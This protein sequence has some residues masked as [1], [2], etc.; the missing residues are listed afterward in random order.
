[1]SQSESTTN[2]LENVVNSVMGVKDP[3]PSNDSN[4]N[5]QEF[6]GKALLIY[7]GGT[8]V[9]IA[10]MVLALW[11]IGQAYTQL[12]R[13]NDNSW[14]PTAIASVFFTVVTLRSRLF[15]PLDNTR[16]SGRYQQVIRPNWAPPPLAFPIVWMT[17][18]VLRIV[19]S[20][21]VWQAVGQNF[22]AVPLI[23]FV[24]HLALGDIWNTIFTVEGRL[25]AAVPVVI[26]GP[27]LSA[28]VVTV[29]YGQTVS[30]AGLLLAPSVV[31]ITVACVLVYSIWRLN[32]CEPWYPMKRVNGGK[33]Q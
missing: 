15:S 4:I 12:E 10:L 1:M 29:L 27:W 19:S 2:R 21:L 3:S 22:L 17:I 33:T 32:G 13:L 23:A 24:I 9:Q 30:L 31:W 25:G 18:G 7:I 14:W 20:V 11:A 16:S 5:T 6:D 28:I 26:M 8:A